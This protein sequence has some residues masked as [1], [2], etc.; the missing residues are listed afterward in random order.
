MTVCAVTAFRAREPCG[1]PGTAVQ[2]VMLLLLLSILGGVV[3]VLFAM[4][5][6]VGVPARW[7][8]GWSHA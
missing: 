8:A 6:L 7:R 4:A 1:F 5:S 2:V 3:L